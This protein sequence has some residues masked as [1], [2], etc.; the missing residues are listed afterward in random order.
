MT[1]FFYYALIANDLYCLLSLSFFAMI[2]VGGIMV[3]TKEDIQKVLAL[4]DVEDIPYVLSDFVMQILTSK[5]DIIRDKSN[6]NKV[7]VKVREGE[8]D[9]NR[10]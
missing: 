7:K 3:I 1:M 6:P 10:K 4:Y 9:G 2:M 8:N 5:M